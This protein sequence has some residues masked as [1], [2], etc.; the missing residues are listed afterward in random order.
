[1]RHYNECEDSEI[2]LG[3]WYKPTKTYDS[4]LDAFCAFRKNSDYKSPG[5]L[6]IVFLQ[7]ICGTERGFKPQNFSTAAVSIAKRNDT[8]ENV[9]DK[10]N[11]FI[12]MILA[13]PT[14]PKLKFKLVDKL[15]RVQNSDKRWCTERF[16]VAEVPNSGS[17]PG[18]S[19]EAFADSMR[20]VE[21]IV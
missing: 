16:V 2:R 15:V 4:G 1:M 8:R 12:E 21:N 19:S 11:L 7:A 6:V 13:V 14:G 3:I 9:P 5:D 18:K 17:F 20:R 10:A